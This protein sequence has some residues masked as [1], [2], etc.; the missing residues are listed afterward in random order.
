MQITTLI[1]SGC[2]ALCAAFQ[3]YFACRLTKVSKTM[4]KVA[5]ITLELEEIRTG[6]NIAISDSRPEPYNDYVNKVKQ[7]RQRYPDILGYLKF[8]HDDSDSAP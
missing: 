5:R 8:P 1:L 3:A 6:I 2:I 4:S 7:L